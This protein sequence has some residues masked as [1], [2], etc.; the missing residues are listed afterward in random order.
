MRA[1][2]S[3]G[4]GSPDDRWH[5]KKITRLRRLYRVPCRD[6]EA[7]RRVYGDGGG[8]WAGRMGRQELVATHAIRGK[9]LKTIPSSIRAFGHTR[10]GQHASLAPSVLNLAAR[11]MAES[12]SRLARHQRLV[13]TTSRFWLGILD[14][15]PQMPQSRPL[16]TQVVSH[17]PMKM[18]V[19]GFFRA[20]RS[21]GL[22]VEGVKNSAGD[23]LFPQQ[24]YSVVPCGAA[25]HVDG[26][27]ELLRQFWLDAGDTE[28][29]VISRPF[30]T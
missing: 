5:G 13:R 30:T 23:A 9:N 1:S 11:S 12:G 25:V 17:L 18:L 27:L 2:P 3:P 16:R 28:G 4:G 20:Q 10:A 21:L 15:V 22:A 7:G 19:S 14:Y 6:K 8:G 24:R 26:Q 29:G